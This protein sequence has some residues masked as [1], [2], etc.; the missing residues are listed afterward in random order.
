MYFA[1]IF[2]NS[3][4]KLPEGASINKIEYLK[5]YVDVWYSLGSSE[6]KQETKTKDKNMNTATSAVVVANNNDQDARD[7]R[8][9]MAV[10]L[11]NMRYDKIGELRKAFRLNDDDPPRTRKELAERLASGKYQIRGLDKKPD[12]DLGWRSPEDLIV[13]RAPDNKPDEAGYEEATKRL[14]KAVEFVSDE[15]RVRSLEDGLAALRKFEETDFAK[16]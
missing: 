9:Y 5:D 6:P 12:A 4:T 2:Y 7:A 13:W 1:Q 3:G 15:I 11:N 14:R 16:E 8:N 10:R